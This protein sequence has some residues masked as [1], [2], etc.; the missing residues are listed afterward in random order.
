MKQ[1]KKGAVRRRTE[2]KR[3][4]KKK[5]KRCSCYLTETTLHGSMEY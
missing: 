1:N 3:H 5:K 2:R 4:R